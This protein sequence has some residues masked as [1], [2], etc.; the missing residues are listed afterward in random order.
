MQYWFSKK[1]IFTKVT[2]KLYSQKY[3]V[4][5]IVSLLVFFLKENEKKERGDV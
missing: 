2:C 4:N 3:H 1:Y 5:Y